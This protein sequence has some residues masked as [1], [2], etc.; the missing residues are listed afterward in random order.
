MDYPNPPGSTDPGFSQG[1]AF[2]PSSLFAVFFVIVGVIVVIGIVSA[3]A[4]QAMIS[5][6]RQNGKWIMAKVDRIEQRTRVVNRAAQMNDLPPQVRHHYVVVASWTD[7]DTGQRYIFSS[8]EKSSSPRYVSGDDVPVL[9]DR[10]DY[11]RYH[12]EI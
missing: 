3:V 4:R 10:S 7:P 5:D 6:L 8:D 9:V 12:V 1:P 2:D 11:N